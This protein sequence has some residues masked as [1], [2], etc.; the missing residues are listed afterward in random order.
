V[1]HEDNLVVADIQSVRAISA[2][3]GDDVWTLR[4]IFQFAPIGTATAIANH[5][6]DLLLTSWLDNSVKVLDPISG[7]ITQALTTLNVPVSA[8]KFGDHYAVTLHG[9]NTLSLFADDGS[10]VS[11]LSDDFD[12]PTHVVHY[13][14]R[15]LVSDR[16]RGEIVAVDSSGNQEVMVAGLNSPEGIAVLDETIFIYEG[17]TG[18]IKRHD[19]SG[20]QVIATLTPG[21]PAATPAQPPS[22]VFNGLTVHAGALF[23]TD[24][25]E[26][27]IYRI[28]L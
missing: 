21:S 3:T 13:G 19:A 20:I 9:D 7:E 6:A 14:D 27:A 11:V 25:R 15:L 1:V 26:R 12:A 17:D 2:R 18:E 22:M 24:E 10:L 5:G 23:A 8:V 16:K 28:P 4:N